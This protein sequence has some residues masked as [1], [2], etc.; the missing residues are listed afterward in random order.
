MTIDHS[1]VSEAVEIDAGLDL[2]DMCL[3]QEL[4]CRQLKIDKVR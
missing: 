4:P 1:S 3:T 2:L